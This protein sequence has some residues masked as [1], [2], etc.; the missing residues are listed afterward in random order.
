MQ[1]DVRSPSF[2]P[3]E[4]DTLV[5]ANVT[6]VP[7]VSADDSPSRALLGVNLNPKPIPAV[8]EASTLM[9]KGVVAPLRNQNVFPSKCAAWY[10]I[11]PE[12]SCA[13]LAITSLNR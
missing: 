4:S 8:V 10:I 12:V 5:D 1:V 13:G 7:A 6:D 11:D 9:D 3:S 2:L